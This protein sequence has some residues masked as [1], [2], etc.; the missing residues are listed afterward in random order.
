[1]WKSDSEPQRHGTGWTPLASKLY[2]VC[3]IQECKTDLISIKGWFTIEA[4][5]ML[6]SEVM[7]NY[8]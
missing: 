6:W 2:R 3:V 8:I 1:L 5:I 4:F 7:T